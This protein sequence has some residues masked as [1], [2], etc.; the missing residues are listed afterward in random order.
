MVRVSKRFSDNFSMKIE[1]FIITTF[2][3]RK[4]ALKF[5]KCNMITE[6]ELVVLPALGLEMN[7]MTA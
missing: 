3:L 1:K 7:S 4:G 2:F 6:I 5:L